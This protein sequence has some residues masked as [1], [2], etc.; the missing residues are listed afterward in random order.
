MS[1]NIRSS[2]LVMKLIAT[3]FLPNLPPLPILEQ[4]KRELRLCD[5]DGDKTS[6]TILTFYPV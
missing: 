2:S 1:F 4:D 6:H 5:G 3:P